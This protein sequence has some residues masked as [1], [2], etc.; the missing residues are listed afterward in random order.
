MN[1]LLDLAGDVGRRA[2][3]LFAGAHI[4][5]RLVQR[6]RFDFTGIAVEYLMNLFRNFDVQ[7]HIHRQAHQLR[8]ATQR[9]G[10]RHGAAHPELA[11]LVIGSRHHT[12]PAGRAAHRHRLAGQLGMLA[13]LDR[14]IKRIHIDV[15]NH[16]QQYN[17][18]IGDA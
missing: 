11:R 9:R 1:S 17:R 16:G 10:H 8:A 14:G 3:Q 2:K 15:D 7:R 18:D 12:T 5:E 4:Q 13:H 6:Q